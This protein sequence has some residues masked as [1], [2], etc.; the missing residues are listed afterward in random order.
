MTP[1]HP[2]ILSGGSGTRLWPLSRAA[3][4]KQLLPLCGERTMLQA[5][6][7]RA[8]ALPGAQAPL[9]ICNQEHRFLIREQSL[10]A[11]HLPSAIYLEPVGRN[12]A[13][14]IALAAL[15]LAQTD[16]DAI[17]L[18]LPADHVIDDQAGFERAV[19]DAVP[20]A[21][22]GYLVTFG[23]L[24]QGPETGYGYIKS[25]PP[26]ALSEVSQASE[27][28][29]PRP[30]GEGTGERARVHAVAAF[31]EK[32]D[33]DTAASYLAA[34]GYTWNSGMF[35]FSARRYLQELGSH[36]P[37]ILAA[38]TAAWQGRAQDLDFC[39]PEG[40]AFLACPSESI[41]YAVMQATTRAAVVSA[42]FGWSD[43]GSWDSLWQIAEHDKQGNAV[44]GDAFVSDTR[45]SYIRAE[46]R[47]VAVIGLD[48]AVVVE[49]AD[50]VLVMHRDKAQDI[51]R[52]VEHLNS[53]GRREHMEHLR[54]Y[55]PWGWYEGIDQGERFQ[56]K[57]IMVKPG[58]K[59]SL[60]MHHHRA[61]HW[62][63]VR[64]TAKVTVDGEVRQVGENQSTY[65]PLGQTHRLENPGKVPLHLIE[66]QSGSYLGEDDIVRFEDTY[67]RT[68]AVAA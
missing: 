52:A 35:V 41:D 19:A 36:R 4:P 60:Q 67:G 47:F 39:R 32:P 10:A 8:A 59:L 27:A 57:R 42:G 53:N 63:V 18:V 49:T 51:K 64:G 15:H 54:V 40:A 31:V 58:D 61:E 55:R 23:I 17:M 33:R 9:L 12:T 56:V 5:T 66:V 29:S 2:V 45:N 25:G 13:P 65:I 34:G 26:L 37:A 28:G 11:G 16:P 30:P 1:I 68:A 46:S 44:R 50:A 20:A 48:N 38:A 62:V 22:A 7:T 3:Y 6:I 24:P 14:A 43:V 21:K